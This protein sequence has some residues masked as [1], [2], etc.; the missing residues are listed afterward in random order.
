MTEPLGSSEIAI[1]E[2]LLRLYDDRLRTSAEVADAEVSRLGALWVARF[3]RV[4]KGFVT[5]RSIAC[6]DDLAGLVDAVCALFD[7]DERIDRFE[8]KT[9]GHDPLPA[10][11][12]VLESRVFAFEDE[13]TVMAGDARAMIGAV[14]A[15]PEGYSLEIRSDEAGVREGEALAARGFAF[16]DEET[17]MAGDARAMT[18]RPDWPSSPACSRCTSSGTPRARSSARGASNSRR[19][20]ASR[21]CGAAPATLPI[22]AKVSTVRSPVRGRAPPSTTASASSTPTARPTRA[23]SSSEPGFTRS[24]RRHPRCAEGS[25]PEARPRGPRLSRRQRPSDRMRRGRRAFR[26]AGSAHSRPRS[27]EAGSAAGAFVQSLWPAHRA[28]KKGMPMKGRTSSGIEAPE[29]IG[30]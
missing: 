4:R 10:L 9:R 25:A 1:P 11:R 20:P 7:A 28:R 23:R 13:E 14:P 18:S 6:D 5:Y 17:V 27:V 3:P 30:P 29:V 26:R 22:A 24:R 21:A 8:W 2:E 16:E 12:G 19:A 15:L